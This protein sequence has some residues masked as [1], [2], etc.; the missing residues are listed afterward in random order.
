MILGNLEQRI[1]LL[2]VAVG[3]VEKTC[4]VCDQTISIENAAEKH[5]SQNYVMSVG[6][7]RIVIIQ[8]PEINYG[9]DWF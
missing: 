1:Y 5:F 6:K 4:K 2:E 7:S 8:T 9:C 3:L